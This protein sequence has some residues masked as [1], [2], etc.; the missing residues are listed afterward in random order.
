M[1]A[2]LTLLKYNIRRRTVM[3]N[4]RTNFVT[5]EEVIKTEMLVYTVLLNW[6]NCRLFALPYVMFTCNVF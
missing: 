3:D 4:F 5:S 6:I 1:D 2:F